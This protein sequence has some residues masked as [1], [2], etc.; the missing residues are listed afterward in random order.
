VSSG[1]EWSGTNGVDCSEYSN[2]AG[3]PVSKEDYLE[4]TI[5][6]GKADDCSKACKDDEKDLCEGLV[7]CTVTGGAYLE[8]T[9]I[10]D[11]LARDKCECVITTS[12]R[13]SFDCTKTGSVIQECTVSNF[14][15]PE[16]V[17][18]AEDVIPYFGDPKFIVYWQTFPLSEDTWTFEVDWKMYGLAIGIAALPIGKWGSAI[19]KAG[20]KESTLIAKEGFSRMTSKVAKYE[21]ERAVAYKSYTR[22]VTTVIG[23]RMY[24]YKATLKAPIEN[25]A[26]LK[27][28]LKSEVSTIEKN[29]RAEMKAAL[30][31]DLR[32]KFTAVV[33]PFSSFKQGGKLV[34]GG[35]AAVALTA[36]DVFDSWLAKLDTYN[37]EILLKQA[38]SK[39]PMQ[40]PVMQQ[41]TPVVLQY[42]DGVFSKATPTLVLAS[43]CYISSMKVTAESNVVCERYARDTQTGDISCTGASVDNSNYPSCSSPQSYFL[44]Q[45]ITGNAD[46]AEDPIV[47]YILGF[48]GYIGTGSPAGSSSYAVP[49]CIDIGGDI[50]TIVV[51]DYMT[52]TFNT[53]EGSHDDGAY[54]TIAD[55]SGELH[56]VPFSKA[57]QEEGPAGTTLDIISASFDGVDVRLEFTKYGTGSCEITDVGR[58]H[59][60]Y[61]LGMSGTLPDGGTTTS[62]AG[63]DGVGCFGYIEAEG[64]C[65]KKTD[66]D[67][68]DGSELYK[69]MNAAAAYDQKPVIE[70][71]EGC[72]VG[73]LDVLDTCGNENVFYKYENGMWMWKSL[74][75]GDYYTPVRA[76]SCTTYDGS[77]CDSLDIETVHADIMQ[78]LIGAGY[79]QGLGVFRNVL[80]EEI[81]SAGRN[82]ANDHVEID[83]TTDEFCGAMDRLVD[84]QY[85]G[86]LVGQF[87]YGP[88]WAMSNIH[89]DVDSRGASDVSYWI[90]LTD[91]NGDYSVDMIG[92]KNGFAG[93][94]VKQMIDFVDSGDGF[95]SYD[96]AWCK[97]PGIIVKDTVKAKD[98]GGDTTN[99]CYDQPT[100]KENTLKAIGTTVGVV[101]TAASLYFA[102]GAAFALMAGSG[103]TAEVF[104]IFGDFASTWPDAGGD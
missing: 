36:A 85:F 50:G 72:V 30:K 49:N 41:G 40:F 89:S 103:V 24:T 92:I 78:G 12:S 43:P 71:E 53:T 23:K 55:K 14:R 84:R 95:K 16:E 17:T 18:N 97:T 38:G 93:S 21:A 99:Y 98:Y 29:M 67:G 63:M 68:A 86:E 15:L 90:D 61:L 88:H 74:D 59:I 51:S 64:G 91:T 34:L 45:R 56:L 94:R 19:V 37:N 69:L 48:T 1:S 80:S 66:S 26:P 102:D 87:R 60:E 79:E 101:G 9:W 62:F 39:E 65:E 54:M 2:N 35:G 73:G 4:M 11:R 46:P 100:G 58:Q 7:Y 5:E 32:E 96:M 22:T 13:P 57:G 8:K 33:N 6:I 104:G 3:K 20:L 76:L 27:R 31:K 44:K 82:T 70:Y 83:Y 28:T 42:K 47:D 52:A 10:I 25:M 77:E 75:A 81:D